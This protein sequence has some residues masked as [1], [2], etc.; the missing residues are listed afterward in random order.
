MPEQIVL[1][2]SVLVAGLRS[3]RGA[4]FRLLGLVDEGE[5]EINLSVP[6][7]LEYEAVLKRQAPALGLSDR[8]VDDVVDFLCSVGHH[9]QLFFLWRP[10]LRDPDDDMVLEL[11]VEAGGATIVT[12]NVR[13]FEGA[14]RFGVAIE[15]PGAFL[16]RLASR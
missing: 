13:D 15:T 4:S 2:T 6:L 11:A 16:R 10:L 5:F 12:H 14:Q 7:V 3:S 8:D 9:R 1:D